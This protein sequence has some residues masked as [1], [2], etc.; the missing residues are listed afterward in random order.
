MP[1]FSKLNHFLIFLNL[2]PVKK[3]LIILA[4]TSFISFSAFSQIEIDSLG[5]VG[6]GTITPTTKLDVN[7]VI[8]ATGGNSNPN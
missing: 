5:N 7:G 4:C 2:F 6:V 1:N 8:K 3:L